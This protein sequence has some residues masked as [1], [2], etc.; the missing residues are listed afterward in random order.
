MGDFNK[1]VSFVL[2]LIVVVVFLAVVT[3]R[4]NLRQRILSANSKKVVAVTP[5][6]T[7]AKQPAKRGFFS[8]LIR[9]TKTPTPT[10][11]K[12]NPASNTQPTVITNYK[13]GQP[14]I[15]TTPTPTAVPVVFISPAQTKNNNEVASIPSTG[16]P[17]LFL[18]FAL[19]SLTAGFFLRKVKK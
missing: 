10:Q 11:H 6:P 4:L 15:I 2:G 14:V 1:V 12:I 13:T 17:T 19:S 7:P 9:P 5:T 16:A 3:G 8:F 18:P